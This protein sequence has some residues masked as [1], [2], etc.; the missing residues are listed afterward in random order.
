VLQDAHAKINVLQLAI[1]FSFSSL[2]FLPSL[3]S[4]FYNNMMHW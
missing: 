4:S 2:S 3:E 1:Q